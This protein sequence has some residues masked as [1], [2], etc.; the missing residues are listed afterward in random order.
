MQAERP[1]RL[2]G[3]T[4]AVIRRCNNPK[5]KATQKALLKANK[6]AYVPA[7]REGYHATITVTGFD[8]DNPGRTEAIP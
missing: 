8:E 2:G 6:A 4:G 7:Q 1:P 3:L 5:V